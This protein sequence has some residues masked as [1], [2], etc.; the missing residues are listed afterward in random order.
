MLWK[1][2]LSPELP[3]FSDADYDNLYVGTKVELD[4]LHKFLRRKVPK[5]HQKFCYTFR[6]LLVAERGFCE[7]NC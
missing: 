7:L 1:F 6:V 3:I 4:N 2:L 5:R